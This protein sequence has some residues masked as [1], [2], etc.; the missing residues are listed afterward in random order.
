MIRLNSVK[1]LIF[2]VKNLENRNKLEFWELLVI[3]KCL[4]INHKYDFHDFCAISKFELDWKI[5]MIIFRVSF[6]KYEIEIKIPDFNLIMIFKI[7]ALKWL[8]SKVKILGIQPNY[9]F[10]LEKFNYSRF[11]LKREKRTQNRMVTIF[12]M[13]FQ[14][15]FIQIPRS[16]IQLRFLMFRNVILEPI[17]NLSN[18]S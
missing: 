16:K 12:T 4:K 14:F 15:I 7:F 18:V 6:G 3:L 17:M 13:I 9:I 2:S 8:N 1:F 5:P 11:C 10:S